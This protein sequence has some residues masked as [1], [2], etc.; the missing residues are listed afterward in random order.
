MTPDET[1]TRPKVPERSPLREVAMLFLRLGLTAFGGPAAPIALMRDE[2][3]RRKGWMTDQEFLDAIGATNIIP[4]PNSTE[5]AI[6]LGNRRAGWKGLLTAGSLFILPATL[7]VLALAVVYVR[8]GSTPQAEWV[9][10]GIKPVM[11]AI[12]IVA[13]LALAPKAAKDWAQLAIGSAAVALY[14]VGVNE[15]ALLFG[16]GAVSV[17]VHFGRRWAKSV[18]SSALLAPVF[19]ALPSLPA[20]TVP[21]FSLVALF[22][23]FL[24]IGAVLYGSGYVLLA[25]VRADFV[26]RLGWLTDRQ[27]IDAVAVGQLTPGPVSTTATF[28]GYV[29]GSWPGAI[30]ATVA[31]FL[32]SFAFVAVLDRLLPLARSNRLVGAAL[33]GINAA[34][35]GLIAGV[36]WQLGRGAVTE[37]FTYVVL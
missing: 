20:A 34:S 10:Y 16:G 22:L 8:Y 5:M 32:P 27:L 19:G 36:A 6:L 7:I 3:V 30:L 9:L 29:V 33:D 26:D 1:S 12:V 11:V 18:A 4:G 35:V 2:V 15:I 28:I 24:K 23:N 14:L 25:Y 17:A 31:I 21:G 37:V 13:L